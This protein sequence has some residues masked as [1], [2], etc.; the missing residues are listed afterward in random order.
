MLDKRRGRDPEMGGMQVGRPSSAPVHRLS[1]AARYSMT[2]ASSAMEPA[3]NG[4]WRP[5]L[6]PCAACA[7]PMLQAPPAKELTVL[8]GP[9]GCPQQ[10]SLDVKFI[11]GG[12]ATGGHGYLWGF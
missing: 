11:Q 4:G 8:L 2:L 6:L 12:P 10:D 5:H 1:P 7:N 9:P 3:P